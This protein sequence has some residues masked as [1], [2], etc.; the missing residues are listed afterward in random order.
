MEYIKQKAK[1]NKMNKNKKLGLNE[2][3]KR[4]VHYDWGVHESDSKWHKKGDLNYLKSRMF[5]ITIRYPT[6]TMEHE[7]EKLRNFVINSLSWVDYYSIGIEGDNDHESTHLH[8]RITVNEMM[9]V[10]HVKAKFADVTDD[11]RCV[12]VNH[13]N[14]SFKVDSVSRNEMP[15][16]TPM[17]HHAYPLKNAAY[18][19][20]VQDITP[21]CYNNGVTTWTNLFDGERDA[22]ETEKEKWAWHRE[23]FASL[24][25]EAEK[26]N[27]NKAPYQINSGNAIRLAQTYANENNMEWS[28]ETHVNVLATMCA[29]K[30]GEKRYTLSS[31]FVGRTILEDLDNQKDNENYKCMVEDALNLKF[32]LNKIKM[33]KLRAKAAAGGVTVT[34][35]AKNATI[36][37]LQMQNKALV[38]E[39]QE[40]N[41]KIKSL[42]EEMKKQNSDS[43]QKMMRLYENN[44]RC[45]TTMTRLKGELRE[46]NEELAIAVMEIEDTHPMKRS[47]E[48][49]TLGNKEVWGYDTS[50]MEDFEKTKKRF[51]EEWRKKPHFKLEYDKKRKIQ[52]PTIVEQ[53]KRPKVEKEE[54]E[55]LHKCDKCDDCGVQERAGCA[56]DQ[57]LPLYMPHK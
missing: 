41:E 14:I 57:G 48:W 53:S 2:R 54:H 7:I 21:E 40:L 10:A 19:K 51:V 26:K 15:N 49:I 23:M 6:G 1:S 16:K 13:E 22:T 3:M 39:Q 34:T 4:Y 42:E 18:G 28:K 5:D 43:N 17:L 33:D 9:T 45:N 24:L 32:A 31:T 56:E 29:D 52:T 12:L 30:H 8:I 11:D 55:N 35:R 25:F 47:S 27:K 36:K 37:A 50:V 44:K 46:R 20:R 38:T